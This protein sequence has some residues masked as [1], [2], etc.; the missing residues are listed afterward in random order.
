MLLAWRAL[1][2]RTSDFYF[3]PKPT[4]QFIWNTRESQKRHSKTTPLFRAVAWCLD[5]AEI[6]TQKESVNSQSAGICGSW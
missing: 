6:P 1:S 2:N 4:T 3:T 5:S